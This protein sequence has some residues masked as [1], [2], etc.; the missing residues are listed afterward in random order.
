MSPDDPVTDE[1]HLEIVPDIDGNLI[2]QAKWAAYTFSE[3]L[4]KGF[5]DWTAQTQRQ[6]LKL[7]VVSKLKYLINKAKNQRIIQ[8]VRLN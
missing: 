1:V 6:H 4:P 2:A 7:H 8:D 3:P 5:A